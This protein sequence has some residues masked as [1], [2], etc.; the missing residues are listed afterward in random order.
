MRDIAAAPNS[1][2]VLVTHIDFSGSGFS[3]WVEIQPGTDPFEWVDSTGNG[4]P[5]AW[6]LYHF[7]ELGVDPNDDPDGDGLTNYEEYLAGT[8]PN[9]WDTSGDLLSDGWKVNNGLD[10]LDPNDDGLPPEATDIVEAEFT[11]GDPSGSH[12]E[13]WR[14]MIEGTG[15][16]D[17]RQMGFHNEDFGAIH[18]ETVKLRKGNGYR[19]TISHVA[20]NRSQGPD[21]DWEAQIDGQPGTD[22]LASNQSHSGSDRFFTLAD[23]WIVDNT[24]GL[25]G[26]VDASFG[27]DD[28]TVGKEALLIPAGKFRADDGKIHHGFSPPN[29]EQGDDPDVYWASVIQNGKCPGNHPLGGRRLFAVGSAQAETG[30]LTVTALFISA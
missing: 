11:I 9:K 24:D 30:S 6:E 13:E 3:T 25:L 10:P 5:D 7:G 27:P 21:Y 8:D 28:H 20:T 19:I 4:L 1:P 29:T 15:P 26:T 17:F 16:E 14:I 22:V 12:S 2:L 18:P 23:H